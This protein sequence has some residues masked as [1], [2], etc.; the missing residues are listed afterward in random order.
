[1]RFCKDCKHYIPAGAEAEKGFLYACMP[2]MCRSPELIS[3]VTGNEVRKKCEDMRG[4]TDKCGPYANWFEQR[5][6]S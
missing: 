4:S 2:A 3:M 6:A 1:M 5:E